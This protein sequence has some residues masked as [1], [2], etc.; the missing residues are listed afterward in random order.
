MAPTRS[1]KISNC[2]VGALTWTKVA[3]KQMKCLT[4]GMACS[5]FMITIGSHLSHL[6]VSFWAPG[7]LQFFKRDIYF[8][9][10]FNFVNTPTTQ[11]SL[12]LLFPRWELEN[13]HG[14]GS[15]SEVPW[16]WSN[17]EKMDDSDA[18]AEPNSRSCVGTA[19]HSLT[20]NVFYDY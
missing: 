14:K 11:Y 7:L 13:Y 12:C 8:K 10:L 4:I 18:R 6:Y 19:F 20:N 17:L 9:A 5:F 16:R 2:I 15:A 3:L 1:S